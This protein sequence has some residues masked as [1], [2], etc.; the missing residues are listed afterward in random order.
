MFAQGR[1]VRI[2]GVL[3]RKTCEVDGIYLD[4]AN[5]K[6]GSANGIEISDLC[7]S[8]KAGLSLI[9]LLAY[10]RFHPRID[11]G[12]TPVSQDSL[13]RLRLP[14]PPRFSNG[15]MDIMVKAISSCVDML[16]GCA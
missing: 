3:I 2:S 16:Y 14:F 7:V 10:P 6:C 11:S 12:R 4:R 13:Y 15:V 9:R 8:A 5:F 1:N